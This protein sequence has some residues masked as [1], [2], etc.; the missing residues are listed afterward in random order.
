[1]EINN[2]YLFYIFKTKKN[3]MFV[4]VIYTNYWYRESRFVQPDWDDAYYDVLNITST[5]TIADFVFQF[6]IR[7]W[8]RYYLS[9]KTTCQGMKWTSFELSLMLSNFVKRNLMW[10]FRFYLFRGN[11]LYVNFFYST[12][13]S[14]LII[15]TKT[16]SVKI[17]NQC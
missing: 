14:L 5:L 7:I 16:V 3:I 8:H 4:K 11:M 15:T 9:Y 1:M 10:Y 6:V 2:F 17:R 13:P 12:N